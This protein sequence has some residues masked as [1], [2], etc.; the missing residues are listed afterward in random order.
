MQGCLDTEADQD[1]ERLLS[2]PKTWGPLRRVPRS[3]YRFLLVG[4]TNTLID[5]CLYLVLT[6][7][8][9]TIALANFISTSAGMSFS[10]LANRLFTFRSAQG[11]RHIGKQAALFL[12]VTGFG[13]WVL[14]PIVI[15]LV[16]HPIGGTTTVLGYLALVQPK[17]CGIAVGVVWNYVLYS[18]LVF[19]LVPTAV[20]VEVAVS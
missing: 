16:P 9:L 15:L 6:H 4:V 13:L 12:V 18:R 8:G 14:Q 3:T 10:F 19:R 20:P 11:H 7:G 2:E 17:L 5:L 1:G